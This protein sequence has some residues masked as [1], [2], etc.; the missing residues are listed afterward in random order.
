MFIFIHYTKYTV[1][2]YL[3]SYYNTI[4]IILRYLI[5]LQLIIKGVSDGDDGTCPPIT[6][7]FTKATCI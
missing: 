6:I 1:K 5:L 7:K 3:F 4:K 2:F